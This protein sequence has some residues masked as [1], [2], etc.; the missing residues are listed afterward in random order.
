MSCPYCGF[1][2]PHLRCGCLANGIPVFSMVRH[3]ITS[4]DPDIL[5]HPMAGNRRHFRQTVFWSCVLLTACACLQPQI[6]AFVLVSMGLPIFCLLFQEIKWYNSCLTSCPNDRRVLCRC[7]DSRVRRLG[8]QCTCAW[9][10]AMF[11]WLSDRLFCDHWL[12]LGMESVSP[13]THPLILMTHTLFPQLPARTVPR[14]N[15]IHV[16]RSLLP[17]RLLRRRQRIPGKR[18]DTQIL[19]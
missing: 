18:A 14:L 4:P 7:T 16:R 11:C 12:E 8:V 10:L 15:L 6:N 19:A 5:S 1:C 3:V 9:L 13:E 2:Q 17:V